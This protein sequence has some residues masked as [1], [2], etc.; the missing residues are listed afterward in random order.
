MAGTNKN[1]SIQD[2]HHPAPLCGDEPDVTASSNFMSSTLFDMQNKLIMISPYST[3]IKVRHGYGGLRIN[4]RFYLRQKGPESGLVILLMSMVDE[5][6]GLLRLTS[7]EHLIVRQTDAN[8]TTE[9][10]Q[11]M[12]GRRKVIGPIRTSWNKWQKQ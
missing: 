3:P 6:G 11:L 9:A 1:M 8:F 5:Y 4:L 2:T 12:V 10:Q 7:E